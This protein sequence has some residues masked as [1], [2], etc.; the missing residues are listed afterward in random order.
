M[1]E[2]LEGLQRNPDE[3]KAIEELTQKLAKSSEK[4]SEKKQQCQQTEAALEGKF[5]FPH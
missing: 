5:K 3:E 4:L 2:T 1:Q